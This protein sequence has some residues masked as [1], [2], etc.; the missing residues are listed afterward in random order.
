MAPNPSSHVSAVDREQLASLSARLRVPLVQFF[1]RR[2]GRGPEAEDLAQEVF[3]RLARHK[4]LGSLERLDGYVFTVA[5]NL[6]RDRAR[7]HAT[8]GGARHVSLEH[9]AELSEEMTPE[10]VLM[11][12]DAMNRFLAAL[13]ELPERT[14]T[15]LMLRRY[16]G[17]EFK[18]IARRLGISVSAIEKHMLRAMDY[19]SQRLDLK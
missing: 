11:G 1:E 16:E 8:Q 6:L 17:L 3:E 18:E 2:V 4:D 7:H 15:V 12:E 9:I 14:R 13:A 19:L 5:V 10:R